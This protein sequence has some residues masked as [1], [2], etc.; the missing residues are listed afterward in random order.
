MRIRQNIEGILDKAHDGKHISRDDAL[1]LM[2]I[3]EKSDE[4]YALMSTAN[5]MT[6]ARVNNTGEVYAQIGINNW[7]CPKNCKFCFFG[8]KWGLVREPMELSIEQVVFRAKEFEKAGARCIFLMTTAN[9][10]FNKLLEIAREVSC[11]LSPGMQLSV[12]IGDF[13]SSEARQLEEAGVHNAYHIYRLR[14]GVDTEIDPATRDKTLSAIR[15]SG[16]SLASCVEPIGPEHTNEE[17]V[18]EIFRALEYKPNLLSVMNRF[19]VPGT[20]L[21]EKGKIAELKL[22]KIAA[23]GR[24]AAGD[25]VKIYAVHGPSTVAFASG[26]SALW[27][28]SGSNP[29]DTEEDTSRGIGLSVETSKQMLRDAGFEVLEGFSKVFKKN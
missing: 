23:A 20:P 8:E 15:N 11:A 17:I 27:A 5:A 13:G 21:A 26:S 18:D 25:K 6:R 2:R 12:N 7:P 9:Y 19:P 4:M 10:P 16:L 29:R 22:A 1:E 14:E 24:L 3:D 28:E